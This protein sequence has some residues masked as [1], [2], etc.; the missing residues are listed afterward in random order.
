MIKAIQMLLAGAWVAALCVIAY[1]QPG[2]TVR[3]RGTIENAHG[4]VLTLNSTDGAA[5]NSRLPVTR[6]SSR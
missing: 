3:L 5:V 2:Q 4:N 6:W 1:A